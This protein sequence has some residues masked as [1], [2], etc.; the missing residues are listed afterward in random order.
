M[1]PDPMVPSGSDNRVRP[2]RGP[3]QA[4]GSS[5]NAARANTFPVCFGFF[6]W[7]TIWRALRPSLFDDVSAALA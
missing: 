4:F 7:T 3:W 2:V 5:A 1:N 6:V